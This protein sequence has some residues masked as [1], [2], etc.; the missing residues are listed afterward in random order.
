MSAPAP[1]AASTTPSTTE[2]KDTE[3][4][5]NVETADTKPEAAPADSKPETASTETTGAPVSAPSVL[6]S[7]PVMGENFEKTV[8]EIMEMMGHGRDEVSQYLETKRF[9]VTVFL[10][11]FLLFLFPNS[12]DKFDRQIIV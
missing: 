7:A 8:R 6:E 4:A 5:E 11:K 3:M 9:A 1:V 10:N 2:T 12:H